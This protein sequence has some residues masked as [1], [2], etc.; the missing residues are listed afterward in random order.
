MSTRKISL[1]ATLFLFIYILQE[2]FITQLR[3]AGGGFSLFLIFTLLWAALSSPNMGALTGFAAG[4][5]IDLSQSTAGVFGQWTLVLILI[6]FGI[7][8]FGLGYENVRLNPFTITFLVT[9]SVFIARVVYLLLSLLL[10]KDLGTFSSVATS[11][12][13]GLLWSAAVVPI[14]MPA[15][16]RAY[17][18]INDTRSRL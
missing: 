3:I 15:V 4:L 11:L 18:F 13:I 12:L 6:G 14:A 17:D 1:T 5:L 7:S 8:Y 2:A 10:G 16:A 9:I